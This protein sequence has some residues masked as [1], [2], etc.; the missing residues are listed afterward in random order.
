M[1]LL[2]QLLVNGVDPNDLLVDA[3]GV[4]LPEDTWRDALVNQAATNVDGLRHWISQLQK[5][6]VFLSAPL[7]VDF[8]LLNAFTPEYQT[9]GIRE[10]GPQIPDPEKD[11]GN[12][13]VERLEKAALRV[14]GEQ[15][16]W[17]GYNLDFMKLFPWYSYLFLD[18]SKPRT[19]FASLSRVTRDR[20]TEQLPKVLKDLIGEIQKNLPPANPEAQ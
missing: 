11:D 20:L 12:P 5:H 16:S 7:D 17:K 9:L 13:Y 14:F 15:G 18:R 4:A 10:N 2:D 3:D 1:Y 6:G 8:L 19:H